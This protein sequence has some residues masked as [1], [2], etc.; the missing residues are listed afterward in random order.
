M[1]HNRIRL[2]LNL[3]VL[4]LLVDGEMGR[5]VLDVSDFRIDDGHVAVSVVANPQA[6]PRAR[7][8]SVVRNVHVFEAGVGK[9]AL[10]LFASPPNHTETVGHAVPD[11]HV[12]DVHVRKAAAI[13]AK[14]ERSPPGPIVIVTTAMSQITVPDN[15]GS[16]KVII[17]FSARVRSRKSCADQDATA[18]GNVR[19]QTILNTIVR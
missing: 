1:F 3:N 10:S 6:V 19:E 8:N 2:G 4:L 5:A 12:A 9:R 18:G 14:L 11:V 13:H 17:N 16:A 15:S 7:P